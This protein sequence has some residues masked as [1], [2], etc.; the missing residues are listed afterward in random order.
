LLEIGVGGYELKTVG[1]ASLAM[2]A[3]YFT[4]GQITGIDVAQKQLSLNPR[5]KVLQGS[6]VDPRFLKA[7]CDQRGPFDIIIDDGSHVPKHVVASFQILFPTLADGGLYVIEDVQTAFWPNFGGSSLHGGDMVKLARTAIECINHAELAVVKASHTLPMFAQQVKTFRAFHNIFVIEKG[8]NRE[9]SNF[10]YD[11][12]NPHVAKAVKIIEQE[13]DK[14]PTPEGMANLVDVYLSGRDSARAKEIADKALSLWPENP[15][16]M[17]GAYKVAKE[18]KDISAQ[19]G[20]LERV[21][22]IE[23]DN[24]VLQERLKEAKSAAGVN[25]DSQDAESK[26]V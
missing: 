4:N 1:G 17:L 11:L 3:D 10:A 26:R 25:R 15:T 23:A 20:Y 9:P 2:W 24:V 6:Q 12:N 19:I 22:R 16:V 21:L 14:A 5:I 7:V 18:R 8:E 13:L